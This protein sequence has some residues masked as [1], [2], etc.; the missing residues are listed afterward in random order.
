MQ[1]NYTHSQLLQVLTQLYSD[2]LESG[3]LVQFDHTGL[4]SLKDDWIRPYPTSR[5]GVWP[6]RQL[7]V[8]MG[9][10]SCLGGEHLFYW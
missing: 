7:A 1:L 10:S 3:D 8:N 9:T 6:P 5:K 4:L 2:L